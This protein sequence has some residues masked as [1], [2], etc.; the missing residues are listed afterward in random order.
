M[1][2]EIRELVIQARVAPEPK[3]PSIAIPGPLSLEARRQDQLI[4]SI[5]SKVLERLRDER[6]RRS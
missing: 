3:T 5:V 4:E 2:I 1:T 6:E